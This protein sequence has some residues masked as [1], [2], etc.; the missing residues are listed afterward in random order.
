MRRGYAALVLLALI[1]GASFLFI[2]LAVQDMS[3]ATVVL[4]RALFGAL[5]LSVILAARRQTPFPT[6][7]RQRLLP[8]VVMAVFGSALP[9]FGISFGEVSISSGLASILNATTPL[10]TGAGHL[11]HPRRAARR[12]QLSR[13]G[14]RLPGNRHPSR[15]RSDRAAAEGD[16]HRHDRGGG[17]GRQLCDR[18]PG[19]AAPALRREPAAGRFLATDAD[20]PTGTEPRA[21][22][23][24][25]HPAAPGLNRL[26]HRARGGRLGHRLPSLLLHDEHAGRHPRHDRHLPAADDRRLLGRDPAA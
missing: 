10:W 16:D 19:A 11:G 1:W 7:T 15:S 25:K 9:W 21:A 22:D 3:P 20:D 14:G 13:G 2:K 5:M 18:R 17:G 4:A 8:F 6:G 23:D 12:V 24:H 26:H